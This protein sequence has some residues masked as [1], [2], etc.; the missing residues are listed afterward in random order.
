MYLLKY[1]WT[2]TGLLSLN[3]SDLPFPSVC[4]VGNEHGEESFLSISA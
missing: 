2:F 1:N 4:E 3:P